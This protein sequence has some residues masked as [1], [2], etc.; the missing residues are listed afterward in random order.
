MKDV[1]IRYNAYERYCQIDAFSV[2]HVRDYE[3][4]VRLGKSEHAKLLGNVR[5]GELHCGFTVQSTSDALRSLLLCSLDPNRTEH[6]G[7]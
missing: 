4:Q 3:R 7:V 1:R 6:S 2:C 5:L